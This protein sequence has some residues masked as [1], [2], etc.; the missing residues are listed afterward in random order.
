MNILIL[1]QEKGNKIYSQLD[2]IADTVDGSRKIN[3]IINDA[4]DARGSRHY[5]IFIVVISNKN[6]YF[7]SKA[8]RGRQVLFQVCFLHIDPELA[9]LQ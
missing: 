2:G 7:A 6:I 9:H 4:R 8:A 5:L 3:A 1:S